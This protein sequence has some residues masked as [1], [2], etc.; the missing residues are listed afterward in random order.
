MYCLEHELVTLL[1]STSPT[2]PSRLFPL[3]L[4]TRL[5]D[6]ADRY[7]KAV[8]LYWNR[9]GHGLH[10]ASGETRLPRRLLDHAG[11]NRLAGAHGL[12]VLPRESPL[13]RG[14][15]RREVG[16]D[17]LDYLVVVSGD[18]GLIWA[19]EVCS[20]APG[21]GAEA[22]G[23]F[24]LEILLGHSPEEL[25]EPRQEALGPFRRIPPTPPSGGP[26]TLLV[27]VEFTQPEHVPRGGARLD[28]L[29][30]L[31]RTAG[32][33]PVG[34]VFQ[35]LERPRPGTFLG[36][37]KLERIRDRVLDEDLHTVLFGC[38]LPY[39][40]VHRLAEGLGCRV[41]DRSELILEIFAQHA[42]T[43][44]GRLQV[45]RARLEHDLHRL[46]AQER[47][48][49][50]QTGVVGAL[51]GPGE[52]GAALVR[53]R[54]HRKKLELDRK[55]DRLRRQREAG[56]ARRARGA[57]PRIALAGYTNAGKS[58]LLNALV[59]REVTTSRDQLF[60][61][62]TTTTRRIPLPGGR[63]SLWSDTVGFLEDL[64]HHLVAAFEST[65]REASDATLTLVVLEAREDTLLRHLRVVEEV[66]DGMGSHREDRLLVLSKVDRLDPGELERIRALVPGALPLSALRGDGL[67]ELLERVEERLRE[68][69]VEATL[70]LPFPRL[71]LREQLFERGLVL[72]EDWH[73]SGVRLRVRLPPE[74]LPELEDLVVPGAA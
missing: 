52:S 18:R 4:V 70:E 44:E 40:L 35:R 30:R 14:R 34:E 1:D 60:T 32:L 7:R 69:E 71:A 23:P 47:D 72:D 73:G 68:G 29:S 25:L 12:R 6:L 49:D 39:A 21:P 27:G 11:T 45:R 3:E 9:R 64:P 20:G 22:L 2:N 37:G 56:R 62:L 16:M 17:H 13:E 50:R 42:T 65:L 48:V 61:T 53:R 51:G 66:L 54:I 58:T 67:P 46:L 26:R 28:E 36:S 74:E 33:E 55:L 41:V 15:D 8:T 31:A 5:V 59:G 24:S 19:P 57:L 63:T 43:N 10:A 38:D